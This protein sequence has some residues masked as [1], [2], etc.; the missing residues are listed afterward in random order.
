M[1][2]MASGLWATTTRM[3]SSLLVDSS[4]RG[5]FYPMIISH[6]SDQGVPYEFKDAYQLLQDFF[7]DVDRVLK[8]MEK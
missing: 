4:M 3:G 2:K 8:E 6:I 5:K 7:A 1:N